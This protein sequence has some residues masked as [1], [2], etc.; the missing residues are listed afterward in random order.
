M[1]E[2]IHM[3]AAQWRAYFAIIDARGTTTRKTIVSKSTELFSHEAR[4]NANAARTL[5]EKKVIVTWLAGT[6]DYRWT[7]AALADV[8][9][10]IAKSRG[11]R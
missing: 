7:E 1:A 4:I 6:A 3:T 9:V 11:E 2:H 5:E 10:L 8:G